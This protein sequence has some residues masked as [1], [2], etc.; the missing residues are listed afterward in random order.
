MLFSTRGCGHL[1]HSSPSIRR[2]EEKYGQFL[3]LSSLLSLCS[4]PPHRSLL[5]TRVPP[6]AAA[7]SCSQI[8]CEP[9]RA[10]A[11]TDAVQ[12]AIGGVSN[13]PLLVSRD[14]GISGGCVGPHDVTPDHPA[15]ARRR[16]HRHEGE[17]DDGGVIVLEQPAR[18]G[19]RSRGRLPPS[20]TRARAGWSGVTSWG[21]THPPLIPISRLTSKG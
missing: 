17:G 6:A 21:P 11:K 20:T 15:R 16:P 12:T 5:I 2:K 9:A 4:P 8:V 13:Q 14:I 1:A 10:T 18:H 19:R 7:A 3:L